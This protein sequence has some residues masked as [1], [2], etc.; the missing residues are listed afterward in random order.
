MGIFEKLNPF[1][2]AIDSALEIVDEAV[3]DKDKMMELR[4]RLYEAANTVYL[5]E[6]QV[7]T[8]PWVD[9]LHKMGRQ[10]LSVFVLIGYVL[11]KVRGVEVPFDELVAIVA[12]ATAYNIVK[13]RGK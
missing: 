12:P 10:M 11:L 4:F 6:L 13:G 7:Q 1:R 8:I 9:A 3:I 5:T 2:G